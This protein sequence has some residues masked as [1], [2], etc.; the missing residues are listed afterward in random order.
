MMTAQCTAAANECPGVFD[1]IPNYERHTCSLLG[2]CSKMVQGHLLYI[3]ILGNRVYLPLSRCRIKYIH[4]ILARR[5]NIE[6]FHQP[7]E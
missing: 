4:Y 1:V 6:C 7:E 2:Y 3:Y 5:V